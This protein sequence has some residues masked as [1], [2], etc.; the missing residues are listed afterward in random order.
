MPVFFVRSIGANLALIE[1]G[2]VPSTPVSVV[3]GW[4]HGRSRLRHRC[5]SATRS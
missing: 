3:V 2:S 1:P 5:G 4:R